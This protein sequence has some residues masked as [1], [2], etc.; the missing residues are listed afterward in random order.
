MSEERPIRKRDRII[1]GFS[2]LL[3]E[4]KLKA[5]S[6]YIEN[7]GEFIALLKSFWYSDVEKQ[8]QFDEF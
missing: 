7:P 3:K 1:K 6:E 4:D 8:R 5:V 2:K